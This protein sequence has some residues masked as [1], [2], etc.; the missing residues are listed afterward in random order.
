MVRGPAAVLVT[1][2]AALAYFPIA[3]ALPGLGDP[4]ATAIVSGA[5]AV[6]ALAA[7]ALVLVG[8]RDEPAALG[9]LV[10]GG[11]L[12]AGALTVAGVGA[13][14]NVARVL[15]AGA[16]GVLLARFFDWPGFVVAIPL[17][18]AGIDVASVAAGPS[19]RLIREQPPVTEFLTF[20]LP[21]WGNDG[22]AQ[23][24]VSDMIFLGFYA[25][26]AW[27]HGFRRPATAVGLVG[28]LVAALI[29]GVLTDRALPVLPALAAGLLLPNLDRI[30]PLLSAPEATAEEDAGPGEE[31]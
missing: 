9:L 6:V 3:P 24:G 10:L 19:S 11:G 28:A 23:L 26:A 17:F 2:G 20:P 18:V 15:F 4:H 1:F 13:G 30:G 25:A 12:V 21:L 14:A 27:R 5:V 29:A 31:P 22:S 8:A 7:C 16:L